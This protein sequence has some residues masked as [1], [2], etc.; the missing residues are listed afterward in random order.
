MFLGT[1][2]CIY[3][4]R[5]KKNMN[6]GVLTGGGDCPGLNAVIRGVVRKAEKEGHTIIGFKNGWKGVLES[7]A[8][9]LD[10]NATRGILHRGGT[11]LGTSRTNPFSSDEEENLKKVKKT[12]EQFA[13]DGLIAIGGEDTLTVAYKLT[14]K[15][16]PVVGVPKTIDNDLNE[17]DCTF[18]F[19]TAVNIAMEA[20]DR[21]HTT[22]ESHSRCIVA[23]I[24]GRHAGWMTAYAAL[25]GSADYALVPEKKVDLNQLYD[26]LKRRHLHSNFSIVAFSEGAHIDDDMVLQ[27]QEKDAFGHV[28]LGGGGECLAQLIEK[29][30]GIE[31][32]SVVL[33]H[34]QRGGS[35]TAFDR[36][37]GL[38]L[39]VRALEAVVNGEFAHMVSL[40]GMEVTVVP[41]EKAVSE[42]KVLPPYWLD[43]LETFYC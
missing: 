19:D 18:G 39:G 30:T 3:Q 17:T 16:F 27:N 8:S 33:G 10:R 5:S 4:K 15:G 14:Q 36:V 26:S 13:L 29:N 25:S 42:L 23:E 9:V 41:I 32:R 31:T 21:L 38:R 28:R 1:Y 12:Y 35:P 43:L 34:V 24:M 40:K 11:I 37:L 20:L 6:F 2:W 22:A 7:N